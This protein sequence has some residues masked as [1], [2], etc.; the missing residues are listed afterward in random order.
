MGQGEIDIVEG[1]N[2]MTPNESTLHTSAGCTMPTSRSETGYASLF[3]SCVHL[4]LDDADRS[5]STYV[6]STARLQPSTAATPLTSVVALTPRPA[7][8]SPMVTT[9][10]AEAG[11]GCKRP[12]TPST[13]GSGLEPPQGFRTMYGSRRAL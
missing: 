5:I 7:T 9:K 2:D 12:P 13:Y 3:H 4:R 6:Y 11:G 8:P 10:S 1:V